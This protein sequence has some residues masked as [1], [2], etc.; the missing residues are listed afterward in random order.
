M[1]KSAAHLLLA[2]ACVLMA[3]M[4][5]YFLGRNTVRSPIVVSKLPTQAASQGL[6]NINT[7]TLEQLQELPGI[8]KTLAQRILDYRNTHGPFERLSDLSLVE[9]IG[10][11]II[12]RIT[13]YAT[14]QEDKQ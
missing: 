2:I 14:V 4:A 11:D 3:L 13:D 8:G 6:L 12:E 10:L 7:A 5:G 1:K 9:G